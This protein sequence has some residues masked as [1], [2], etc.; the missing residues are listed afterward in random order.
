MIKDRPHRLDLIYF[1]W[2]L[3]LVTFCTR[4]RTK[5]PSLGV[6]QRAIENYA[7][8]GIL[9][10]HVATGRYVIMPDQVHLSSEVITILFFQRGSVG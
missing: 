9:N 2:P 8:V 3:Y 6:A 1:R 5:I 10:F 4:N 7:Q